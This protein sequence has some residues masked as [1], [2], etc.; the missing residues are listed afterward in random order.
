MYEI[1]RVVRS[2]E[3]AA[4]RPITAHHAWRVVDGVR[5][6]MY[7]HGYTDTAYRW[8]RGVNTS[9]IAPTRL[10]RRGFWA[11]KRLTGSLKD[12]GGAFVRIGRVKLWGKIVEHRYGYR[13]EFAKV[14]R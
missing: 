2:R 5:R 4:S 9:D 6:S 11:F 10:N 13:A 1:G 12:Y 7:S 3:V 14:V 8:S